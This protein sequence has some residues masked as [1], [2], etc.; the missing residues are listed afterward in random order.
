MGQESIT[1]EKDRED[2][3]GSVGFAGVSWF[4]RILPHCM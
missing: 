3:S 2:A 4:V 1:E